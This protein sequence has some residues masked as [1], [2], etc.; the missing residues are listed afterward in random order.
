MAGVKDKV[1]VEMKKR[2]EAQKKKILNR[3]QSDQVS[4][5][6]RK[7]NINVETHVETK[8]LF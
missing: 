6:S 3:F 7:F 1:K 4:W 8:L 2:L 5:L